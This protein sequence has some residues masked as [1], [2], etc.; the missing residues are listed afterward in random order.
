MKSGNHQG[1]AL[2]KVRAL[3]E[4]GVRV[5][6]VMFS[7]KGDGKL[8]VDW[9]AWGIDGLPADWRELGLEG[10]LSE[11]ANGL[12]REDQG[13]AQLHL[14]PMGYRLRY[15]DYIMGDWE[16]EETRGE[17]GKYPSAPRVPA[18]YG[19]LKER[20]EHLVAKY[21]DWYY[22]DASEEWRERYGPEPTL[23]AIL[24]LGRAR[25]EWSVLEEPLVPGLLREIL[26]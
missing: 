14:Y 22:Y 5:L 15:R 24:N 1:I 26:K 12:V 17:L 4:A 18:W 8:V 6:E 9:F 23:E 16:L 11:L 2:E 10:A 13:F 7:H 19:S 20:L 25:E 3:Y 21:S